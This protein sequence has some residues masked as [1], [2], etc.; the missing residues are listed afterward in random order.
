MG[1]VRESMKVLKCQEV[2]C[3]A[4]SSG[5]PAGC[6]AEGRQDARQEEPGHRSL[7]SGPEGHPWHYLRQCRYLS[8]TTILQLSLTHDSPAL[9]IGWLVLKSQ[10]PNIS[11]SES[12]SSIRSVQAATAAKPFE[13]AGLDSAELISELRAAHASDDTKLGVDV[14]LGK[15]GDMSQLGIFECYRVRPVFHGCMPASCACMP[16]SLH[17]NASVSQAGLAGLMVFAA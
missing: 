2:Y 12:A 13:R 6:G 1:T 7:C 15:A 8:V 9:V 4:W 16:S 14:V 5:L 17:A 11:S 3:L 10:Q